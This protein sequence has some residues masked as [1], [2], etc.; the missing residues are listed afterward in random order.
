L[1]K[2]H[3]QADQQNSSI[4]GLQSKTLELEMKNKSL[5]ESSTNLTKELSD[6]SSLQSQTLFQLQEKIS[7]KEKI[8]YSLA[9]TQMRLESLEQALETK[10]Q[11]GVEQMSF[12]K[13]QLDKNQATVDELR[14]ENLS[15]K[16]E[17]I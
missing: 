3:F 5:Q 12:M 11:M 1:K 14:N 7:E 8:T 15:Q 4:Q 6:L 10:G 13:I 2:T 9:S 17:V 16:N